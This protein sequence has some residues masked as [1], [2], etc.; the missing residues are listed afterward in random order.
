MAIDQFRDIDGADPLPSRFWLD[1]TLGDR[2]RKAHRSVG[3]SQEEFAATLGVNRKSLAAWE[4]D[5]NEPRNLLALARRM[6][7]AY[8]IPV[9]WTLGLETYPGTDSEEPRPECP[10]RGSNPRPMGNLPE[11][12]DDTEAVIYQ[13]P[14]RHT[15]PEAVGR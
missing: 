8:K 1:W 12:T 4:L 15:L 13:F 6:E 2:L 14:R 9:S 11:N 5:T 10:Q 3:V 7:L